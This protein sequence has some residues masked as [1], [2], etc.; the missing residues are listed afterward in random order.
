M[1]VTKKW[2][3]LAL[4]VFLAGNEKLLY[5]GLQAMLADDRSKDATKL[6]AEIHLFVHV[7]WRMKHVVGAKVVRSHVYIYESG[8]C[9]QSYCGCSDWNE[10]RGIFWDSCTKEREILMTGAVVILQYSGCLWVFHKNWAFLYSGTF[11]R[12][13][14]SVGQAVANQH[15]TRISKRNALR[16]IKD[17]LQDWVQCRHEPGKACGQP[18]TRWDDD[19][20]LLGWL[21][22]DER[23][24][25]YL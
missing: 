25:C 12:K 17:A 13:H 20:D 4:K 11:V 22:V 24:R 7:R 3:R 14:H 21:Q 23:C 8:S 9:M 16:F 10:R 15:L 6:G 18:G 19:N 2:I 1:T 5:A